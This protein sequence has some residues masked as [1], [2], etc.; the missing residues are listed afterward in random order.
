M[1][2]AFASCFDASDDS[3]QNVWNHVLAE[4]PDVLLL[5]GDSI[6]MDFGLGNI[7]KPRKWSETKFAR[8]MYEHYA[9][10]WN[11]ASFQNLLASVKQVGAI[12][13][14]HDYAWNN[15]YTIGRGGV[16]RNKRLISKGLHLQF[17]DQLR[18]RPLRE[19]YPEA[20]SLESLLSGEDR[21]IEE[22]FDIGS[23]RCI[24]TDGRYY[25][26]R[27]NPDNTMLG[28]AQRDWIA[29]QIHNWGGIAVMCAGSTLSRGG[30]GWDHYN[31]YPWLLGQHFGRTIVLTGDIHRNTKKKHGDNPTLLELTSSGAA[32]PGFGGASGNFG[33]LHLDNNQ[34]HVTLYDDEGPEIS[35]SIQLV[36]STP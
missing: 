35:R 14:D 27:P 33:I 12:W 7:G 9:E 19:T 15:S 22:S 32:R 1:R 23:V 26:E 18:Q 25:R 31:D 5:L 30:E 21:G 29:S 6:Y 2:I 10:Q 4:S 3:E 34:A 24:M 20:P 13:D 17:R 8:K 11:V 36:E 16:P 28:I